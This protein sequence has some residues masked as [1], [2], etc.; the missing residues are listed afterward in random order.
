MRASP[1]SVKQ[2]YRLKNGHRV[3]RLH[4]SALRIRCFNRVVEE[5]KGGRESNEWLPRDFPSCDKYDCFSQWEAAPEVKNAVS[6][7]RA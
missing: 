4:C 1:G 7:R 2:E 6:L 3:K 5:A